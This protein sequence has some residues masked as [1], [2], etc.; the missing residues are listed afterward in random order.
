[1]GGGVQEKGSEGRGPDDTGFEW[2]LSNHKSVEVCGIH[3][4][5]FMSN[6]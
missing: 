1:M 3:Y 2:Q 6:Y 5:N 4:Y